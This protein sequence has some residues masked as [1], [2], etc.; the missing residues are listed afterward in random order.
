M[1]HFVVQEVRWGLFEHLEVLRAF[2]LLCEDLQ[3]AFEPQSG[4]A[5]AT[6]ITSFLLIEKLAASLLFPA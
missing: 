3:R 6:H 5:V 1:I 4:A 2:S